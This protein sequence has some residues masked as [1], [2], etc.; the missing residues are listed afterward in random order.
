MIATLKRYLL[1]AELVILLLMVGGFL[2]TLF[3][4]IWLKP[5]LFEYTIWLYLIVFFAW[6]PVF[7]IVVRRKHSRRFTSVFTIL[8]L[9]LTIFFVANLPSYPFSLPTRTISCNEYVSE[10]HTYYTCY[11]PDSPGTCI[12]D[13]FDAINGLPLMWRNNRLLICLF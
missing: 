2:F 4:P 9:F 6:I 10:E 11:T 12:N 3:A 5:P 1:R 7:L 13:G 8:G